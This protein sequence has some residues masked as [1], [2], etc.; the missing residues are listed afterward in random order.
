MNDYGGHLRKV[1]ADVEEWGDATPR[2][3]RERCLRAEDQ[4]D[5]LIRA[6]EHVLRYSKVGKRA[7][8]RL[9]EALRYAGPLGSQDGSQS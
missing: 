7:E 5:Y 9:R 6:T 2:R 4:R 1:A 3:V 8:I